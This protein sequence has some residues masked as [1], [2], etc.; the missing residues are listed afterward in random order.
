MQPVLGGSE[1]L[2]GFR[3]FRFY[4]NNSLIMNG[5]YR[6]HVVN[7]I[8][9]ALFA[10]AG[11]VF[12]RR[13]QLNF[14]NLEADGGIG[15]RFNIRGRQFLRVDVAKGREGFRFWLKFNDVFERHPVGT[16][17]AQPIY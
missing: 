16:A 9:M 12:T 17:S 8:S 4:D 5:E 7:T 2:R 11:K 15:F 1:D 6:W 10:D 3:S 14:S 13:G